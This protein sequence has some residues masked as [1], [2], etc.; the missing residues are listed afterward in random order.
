[1]VRLIVSL[2]FFTPVFAEIIDL[3]KLILELQQKPAYMQPIILPKLET[4]IENYKTPS[5]NNIFDASRSINFDI[6]ANMN[7]NQDYSLNQL[8]MVGYMNYSGIDYAFLKTPFDTIKVK[9]GDS[10]KGGKV[11]SI[12]NS[13]VEIN[14]LQ[15]IDDKNYNKR[16]FIQLLKPNKPK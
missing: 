6:S 12:T 13:V 7:Y 5:Q 4:I 1:M 9:V 3:E 16:I 11:V 8:Q 15:I 10:I 14:Q 2:L